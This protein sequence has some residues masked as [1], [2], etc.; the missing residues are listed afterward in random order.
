MIPLPSRLFA[1]VLAAALLATAAARAE[2][3]SKPEDNQSVVRVTTTG[4]NYDFYRPWLK[5]APF[6]RRALGAILSGNRILVTAEVV[7]NAAYIELEK[8]EGG[9]KTP[10]TVKFVDYELNLALLEAPDVPFFSDLKPIEL[11]EEAKVGTPLEIWQLESNGALAPTEGAINT[12]E[13]GRYPEELGR[14]LLYR[15][16]I[17]LQFRDPSICLPAILKGK[18]A[19]LLMRYDSRSQNATILPAP[20]IG[21]F[22]KDAADGTYTGL[23]RAGISYSPLRDPQLRR[24]VKA[25]KE[26]GGVYISYVGND[27]PAS[28]AGIKE[29]DVL[30][31]IDGN[32]I[33]SDG[34]YPDP[35]F[36]KIGLENLL[37]SRP[38]G[39]T[40]AL[41]LL[42]DGQ[43]LDVAVTLARRAPSDYVSPPYL[44]DSQPRYVVLGGLVF[45]E[46]SRQYLREW[47]PSW[48][49]NAPQRL[50]YQ[51][52]FQDQLFKK[53]Q[54][55]LVVLS[56]VL[57]TP[58][59]V[60][61]ERLYGLI[62]DKLNGVPIHSLEDL[63]KASQSPINGFQKIEFDEDPKVIYLDNAV[64]EKE[65]PALQKVYSLPQ[66]K[67]LGAPPEKP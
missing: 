36:G 40:V 47:G 4:Q 63:D 33:D 6:Q 25:D 34:N 61:Y 5:K 31:S 32:A 27:S 15:M 39:S 66:L 29:G 49:T 54:S 14:M 53:D 55:H 60:G 58:G 44:Y 13:L 56:Q 57:P 21:Q 18:L 50:V 7:A 3:A 11:T 65:K 48:A 38:A 62:V 10:A 1:S 9:A 51:D 41:K 17:S 8:A 52:A 12:I 22:L 20:V 43:P 2:T 42:R 19:G 64:I 26:K 24:Y 45:Q 35:R 59:T 23:G 16:S 28:K 46:L 67:Y 30:L 37:V